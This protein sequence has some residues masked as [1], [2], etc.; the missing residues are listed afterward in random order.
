[1]KARLLDLHR[2]TQDVLVTINGR[3]HLLASAKVSMLGLGRIIRSEPQAPNVVTLRPVQ[4]AHPNRFLQ[5][6]GSDD[7]QF[8]APNYPG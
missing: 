8:T 1:M 7:Y 4:D 5:K 3:S 2:T 6:V